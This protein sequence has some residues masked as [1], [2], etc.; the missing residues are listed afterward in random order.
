MLHRLSPLLAVSVAKSSCTDDQKFC[1]LQARLS[2]KDVRGH[3][4]SRQT[5]RRLRQRDC[6]YPNRQTIVFCFLFSRKICCVATFDFATQ[7]ASHAKES[8]LRVLL[9]PCVNL[10][11][12]T[13][14]DVRQPTLKNRQWGK[15]VGLARRTRANH[16]LAPLERP[17]R[18]LNFR[19][20]QRIR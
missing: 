10:S 19:L 16:C 4:L 8:R 9:K 17:R 13:A 14:S 5:H 15:S 18:R 6:G 2:C 1:G 20:A 11:I 7:S 12:H 3:I